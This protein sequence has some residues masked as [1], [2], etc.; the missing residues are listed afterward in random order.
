M[1]YII[2]LMILVLGICSI[3]ALSI[4][5]Y[6]YELD[7]GV[8]LETI[9]GWD[10]VHHYTRTD[11]VTEREEAMD[12]YLDFDD[13]GR[14]LS[15]RSKVTIINQSGDTVQKE[16][17]RKAFKLEKGEYNIHVE[18]PL[19][20]D[21]GFIAYK[22]NGIDIDGLHYEDITLVH[23]DIEIFIEKEKRNMNGL[24]MYKPHTSIYKG[25]DADFSSY[26]KVYSNGKLVEPDESINDF[27]HKIKPNTYDLVIEMDM[28]W[29]GYKYQITLNDFEMSGNTV[30]IPN[31]NLN[32]GSF[33][34]SEEFEEYPSLIH[35]YPIGTADKIGETENAALEIYKVEAP[36]GP[37]ICPPGGYDILLNYD[38]GAEY[39]WKKNINFFV[40]ETA[41]IE[42]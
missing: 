37:Y 19:I 38:Y 3:S 22:I 8:T 35:F 30:Y 41:I 34:M 9:N 7:N 5:D 6:H 32:A 23:H 12:L 29:A 14:L 33:K 25:K 36:R 15:G 10:F 27:T 31:I 26:P 11:T 4:S 24:A 42:P 16:C 17:S 20:N 18:L 28:S 21:N 13:L 1:K 40:G 39:Q 2:S